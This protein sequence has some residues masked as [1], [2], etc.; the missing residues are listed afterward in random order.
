V[1]RGG[2]EHE[3]LAVQRQADA[4]WHFAAMLERLEWNGRSR[5]PEAERLHDRRRALVAVFSDLLDGGEAIVPLLR[6]LRARR[7]DVVVFHVLDGDELRLPMDAPTRF[8]GLEGTVQLVVDPRAVRGAYLEA[9][10]R[11][12]AV[13]EKGCR[14]GDISYQRVDTS[15]PPS[16]P[17]LDFLRAR[18]R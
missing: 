3:D 10:G 4:L 6:G 18:R 11:F 15:R 8:E 5:R 2:G 16:E 9:L 1:K 13:I 14:E 17:L 7:H 12:L